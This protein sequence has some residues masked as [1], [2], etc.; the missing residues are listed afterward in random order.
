MTPG[1][2]VWKLMRSRVQRYYSDVVSI[3][4]VGTTYDEYGKETTARTLLATVSGQLSKAGGSERQHVTTIL[5]NAPV[6]QGIENTEI[7]HLALPYDTSLSIEHEVTTA[8]GKNWQVT[9]I[10]DSATFTAA[11]EA[12]IYRHLVSGQEVP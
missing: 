8:D 7:M 1:D 5:S 12:T 9:N 10:N 3:Y 11:K 6:D 2:K 4:S